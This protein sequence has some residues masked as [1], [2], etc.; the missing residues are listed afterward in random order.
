MNLSLSFSRF[1]QNTLQDRLVRLNLVILLAMTFMLLIIQTFHVYNQAKARIGER[2]LT[3]SLIVAEMPIVI[4]AATLGKQNEALNKQINVLRKKIQA[5]FI[6]IGNRQGIRLA[7]PVHARLGQPMEGG[8]NIKPFAGREVISIAKGSLGISVRGKVPI[9]AGGLKGGKVI[10]V[11]STGYL[12]PQTWHLM[13]QALLSLLPWFLLALGLGTFS[14]ILMARDLRSEILDL[15]PE[16]IAVLAQQQRAVLAALRDGVIAVSPENK[17]FLMSARAAEFLGEHSLPHPLILIWPELADLRKYG[18]KEYERPLKQQNL[19]ITLKGQPFLVN[20]EPFE[21]GGYI[22]AFRDRAEALALADELT[23]AR[24]FVDVLRAQTHEYQ[25]RL[26]VISGLLQLGRPKEALRVLNAEIKADTQFRSL[27]KDIQ[28][29]RLVALLVGKRE[30]AQEL[31]IDFQVAEGSNLSAVWERHADTLITTIGNLTENA[32]EA[33][34][35]MPGQVIVVIGEDPEGM[36]IEVEDDGPGVSEQVQS[37]LFIQGGST[38]GTG[39]GYGLSGVMGRIKAL[40]GTM[41]YT[42]REQH[43]VFLVSLPTP[44]QLGWQLKEVSL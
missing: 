42:R 6:V 35:G 18:D 19:E 12:M 24:G 9:W 30:R 15:E 40:G 43:T 31:G 2:A 13:T 4:K 36:Q 44:Q 33:L 34:N 1:K 17:I 28:V 26:H 23:H 8:D 27:M 37:I 7:H 39:R 29:P 20:L 22:A 32:F 5:D 38:K 3:T 16:Q 10:G 21:S 25:N 11:V 14:A 41:R